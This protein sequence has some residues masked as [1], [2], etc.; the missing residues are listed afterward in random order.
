MR[1]LTI[2]LPLSRP[3]SYTHLD[4]YK[5]QVSRQGKIRNEQIRE[6]IN[7]KHAV[8]DE[9]ERRQ[10]IWFGHVKRMG[11]ERLPK[12][13]MEWLPPEKRKRGRP[14][15]SWGESIQKALSARNL[16]EEHC[17]D[18]KYWRESLEIGQR[19]QTL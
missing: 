2:L 13:I 5:R 9:I 16:T 7:V 14:R 17:Q 8:V 11:G 15:R 10:L 6:M 3:V 1:C 12:R 19:R 18:K 4:V